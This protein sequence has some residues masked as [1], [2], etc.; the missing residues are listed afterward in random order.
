M[1]SELLVAGY[2]K[3]GLSST[4]GLTDAERRTAQIIQDAA[5]KGQ[6]L[7]IDSHSR[8]TMTTQNAID[9]LNANGGVNTQNGQNMQLTLHNLGAA[10]SEGTANVGLQ[11]ITGNPNAQV[12]EVTHTKDLVGTAV[13]G[14]TATPSYTSTD[15]NGTLTTTTAKDDGKGTFGNLGN[16]LTGTATPHNC[17]GTSGNTEGCDKQWDK[18]PKSNAM[19][20]DRLTDYKPPIEIS[21]YD[22]IISP[23]LMLDNFVIK[24]SN[25]ST[26]Q[27]LKT[28]QK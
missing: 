27:L 13:G 25:E 23:Y 9:Y 7:Q 2:S 11:Q 28:N 24:Q 8:G 22:N 16:I 15:A 6:A 3:S 26:N 21:S 10:Q 17:Y 19:P 1:L 14:N 4:L 18:I 5:A 20:V 12:Y